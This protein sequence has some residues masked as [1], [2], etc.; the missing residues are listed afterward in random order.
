METNTRIEDMRFMPV[1]SDSNEFIYSPMTGLKEVTCKNLTEARLVFRYA[2]IVESIFCLSSNGT[3][4]IV[5]C[6]FDA[7]HFYKENPEY[8]PFKEKQ[9]QNIITK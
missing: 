7:E 3:F 8:S 2:T 4:N 9:C 5:H 1:I 6:F